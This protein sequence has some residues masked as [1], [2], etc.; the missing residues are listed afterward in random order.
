[1]LVQQD[2]PLEGGG[3]HRGRSKPRAFPEKGPL[4]L[5]DHGNPVRYRNIWYRPLPKRA[6]EGGDTSHMSVEA[7]ARKKAEIAQSIR[8][9]AATQSGKNQ[10]LR[11]L[12]SLC[13]VADSGA[14]TAATTW[15]NGWL[16]ECKSLPVN[17]I[18][19]RKG[20]IMQVNN[21]VSYLMKNSF[22]PATYAARA[23]L[24]TIIKA[25]G[26]DKK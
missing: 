21:A 24:E 10:A 26:W 15:I 12:E 4:K 16:A 18:E 23:E 5:Q 17:A 8:E 25:R 6:A 7:T 2:T 9:D 13:Y 14:V 1:V 11:Y 3:G 19:E 20:D 22:L